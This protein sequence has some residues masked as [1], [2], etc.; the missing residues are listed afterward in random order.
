[1]FDF[2]WFYFRQPLKKFLFYYLIIKISSLGHNVK[3]TIKQQNTKLNNY[4]K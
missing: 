2:A 3:Y 1:M 4:K